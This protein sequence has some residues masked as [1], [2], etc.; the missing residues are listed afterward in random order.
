MTHMVRAIRG[1]LLVAILGS[2][3]SAHAENERRM[4]PAEYKEMSEDEK[5]AARARA[6][7]RMASWN[8]TDLPPEYEFPWKPVVFSA[9]AI[10]IA[11]PFALGAYRR[12]SAEARAV[13][14]GNAPPAPRKRT[15]TAD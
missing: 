11:A 15:K 8:E 7:N 5:A 3:A 12:F 6:R 13:A 14:E 9:L 2:S 10:L 4:K 1:L